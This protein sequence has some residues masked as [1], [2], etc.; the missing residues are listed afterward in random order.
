MAASIKAPAGIVVDDI[1]LVDTKSLKAS[2]KELKIHT[3]LASLPQTPGTIEVRKAGPGKGRGLFAA[4]DLEPGELIIDEKSF[5]WEVERGEAI[6]VC[7]LPGTDEAALD[8]QLLQMAPYELDAD[9]DSEDFSARLKEIPT[10]KEAIRAAMACNSFGIR[11]ISAD[12]EGPGEGDEGFAT[13]RANY[14]YEGRALFSVIC[15]TNHSCGPNCRVTQVPSSGLSPSLPPRYRMETRQHIKAGEELTIS[16][17]P[18]SWRKAKRTKEISDTWGF[19]CDCPR[20]TAPYDDT[21]VFKCPN[22]SCIDEASATGQHSI[23]YLGQEK[24]K[25]C[26]A[27]PSIADAKPSGS[28]LKAA[29]GG[30]GKASSDGEASEEVLAASMNPDDDD[31]VISY[32]MGPLKTEGEVMKTAERVLRCPGPLRLA[33]EDARV[34]GCAN[35]LASLLPVFAEQLGGE[36]SAEGSKMVELFSEVSQ[37]VALASLRTTFVNAKDLGIEID[38]SEE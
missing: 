19:P 34:F 25:Q 8:A 6:Q 13:G 24:C 11:D 3:K 20:C 9:A 5:C 22:P 28:E 14:G 23:I 35:E 16:Y 4:R 21:V 18:R 36:E 37:A 1:A 30:A 31:A 29:A 15:L 12:A 7:V 10:R 33:V 2:S 17:I 27:K 26:G 32:M 38:F